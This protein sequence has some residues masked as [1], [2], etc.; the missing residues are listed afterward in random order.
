MV[1]IC[2]NDL[3]RAW[4]LCLLKLFEHSC[5]IRLFLCELRGL[6]LFMISNNLVVVENIGA[7]VNFKAKYDESKRDNGIMKVKEL[8]VI[9]YDDFFGFLMKMI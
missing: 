8:M 9:F 4:F 7:E 5:S 1:S 6:D 2:I 3:D